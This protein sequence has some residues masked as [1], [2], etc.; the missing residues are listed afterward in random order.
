[1]RHATRYRIDRWKVPGFHLDITAV[2]IELGF[3]VAVFGQP[4]QGVPARKEPT[5]TAGCPAFAVSWDGP[6]R[7]EQ[8]GANREKRET[9]RERKTGRA[10]EDG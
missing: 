6:G 1:M 8:G 10:R 5:S 9:G 3:P 4:N 7:V 2:E